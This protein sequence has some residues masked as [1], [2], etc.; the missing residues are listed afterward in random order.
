M[1]IESS[2]QNLFWVSRV[3]VNKAKVIIATSRSQ[4]EAMDRMRDELQWVYRLRQYMWREY[5]VYLNT[6]SMNNIPLTRRSYD[7]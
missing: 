4:W 7:H 3:N 1:K 2:I 5:R 6:P